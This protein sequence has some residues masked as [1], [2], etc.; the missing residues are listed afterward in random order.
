MPAPLVAAKPGQRLVPNRAPRR[1][2]GYRCRSQEDVD[3]PVVP[4][5]KAEVPESERA[6]T[7]QAPIL[8]KGQG[9]A[10][11]TGVISIVFGIAY[12]V[13]VQLL[14]MRGSELLPPPPE[15]FIP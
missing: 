6:S 3:G 15:A 8:A 12:L 14:D 1:S 11:V 10:I 5:V 13:L 4:F 7:I 2:R 9:T